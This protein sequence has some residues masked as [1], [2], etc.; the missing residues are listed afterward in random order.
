M[1]ELAPGIALNLYLLGALGM[2]VGLIAGF[3]GVSG[4]YMLTPILMVMGM[5][6]PL[7]VG[8]SV[9]LM[10]ANNLIGVIRHRRMGHLDLKMGLITAAGTM[11]GAEIGVRILHGL[12]GT[13]G[14]VA[15]IVVLGVL[16]L[17]LVLVGGSMLREVI[18][19]SRTLGEDGQSAADEGE[20]HTAACDFLQGLTIFP[21]I[22]FT[23]S[24]LR[25]SA[26]F[27]LAVGM[28]IGVLSGF[29]GIGG[30]FMLCPALIYL[31][32]QPSTMA[33]GTN[34]LG[35]FVGL[36]FSTFRHGMLGNVELGVALSMLVATGAGTFIGAK[37]TSHVKGL[38]VRYVLAASVVCAIFGPVCTLLY[39]L[40]GA[41]AWDTA[42]K[43]LTIALMIVPV[44]AVVTLLIM[45]RRRVR[46]LEVAPW[47]ARL[48]ANGA[49]H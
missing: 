28:G 46:G 43:I 39:F 26:W 15:D 42:A 40:S 32:G 2:A 9:A 5:P 18:R 41:G 22:R 25:I 35:L 33:V 24:K 29:L 17:T 45:A 34:L 31:I 3:S 19:S 13:E 20:V 30:G 21:H 7:A 47:A 14:R 6:A 1:V 27:V 37:G 38:A 10:S 44:S 4:G 36:A 49:Q 11:G 16:I 12:Q 23:K 8:S 48:M